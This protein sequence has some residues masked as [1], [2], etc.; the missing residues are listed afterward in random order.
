VLDRA[1]AGNWESFSPPGEGTEW[2][3]E[4]RDLAAAALVWN[5]EVVVHLQVFPKVATADGTTVVYR[6]RIRR[7]YGQPR[8]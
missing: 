1:I 3:L 6:P 2:R 7:N 4:E 8:E 5:D